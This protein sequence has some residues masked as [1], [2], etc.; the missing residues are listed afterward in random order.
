MG[1]SSFDLMINVQKLL[2]SF[3]SESDLKKMNSLSVRENLSKVDAADE[4]FRNALQAYQ[5]SQASYLA[6]TGLDFAFKSEFIKAREYYQRAC[7]LQKFQLSQQNDLDDSQLAENSNNT[8]KCVE[9]SISLGKPETIIDAGPNFISITILKD[10]NYLVTG[11]DHELRFYDLRFKLLVRH[12]GEN[13]SDMK[14]FKKNQ[15][16]TASNANLLIWN[17]ETGECVNKIE[18]VSM[19][20][21]TVELNKSHSLLLAGGAGQVVL[22]DMENFQVIRSYSGH[23]SWIRSVTFNEAKNQLISGSD[24]KSIRIWNANDNTS[25]RTLTGHRGTVTKLV[26]DEQTGWLYSTSYDKS[27]REWNVDTGECLRSLTGHTDWIRDL[28]VTRTKLVSASHDHTI[29]VWSK[30]N[31]QVTKTLSSTS[32]FWRLALNPINGQLISSTCDGEV[33]FWV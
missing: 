21:F 33:V 29:L 20:V 5:I 23:T 4:R 16:I 31:G 1:Q 30:Q 25:Q 15:L 3:D 12:F 14:P 9:L 2:Q 24:D 22:V 26:I 27:I 7:D 8:E 10:L 32:G 28:I 11:G 13:V 19:F 6:N 17:A 18:N